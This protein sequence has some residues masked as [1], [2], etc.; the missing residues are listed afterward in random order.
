MGEAQFNE[1]IDGKKLVLVKEYMSCVRCRLMVEWLLTKYPEP[2]TRIRMKNFLQLNVNQV[3]ADLKTKLNQQQLNSITILIKKKKSGDKESQCNPDPIIDAF[4]K[5]MF[6]IDLK[7]YLCY[8]T[9]SA[10]NKLVSRY[11]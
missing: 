3:I 10:Y 2:W 5:E 7:D 8:Q 11:I 9:L 1:N 6:D 4:I